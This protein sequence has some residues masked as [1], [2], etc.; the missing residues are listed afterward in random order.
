MYNAVTKHPEPESGAGQSLGSNKLPPY[1]LQLSSD[2]GPNRNRLRQFGTHAHWFIAAMTTCFLVSSYTSA[3]AENN[4][5]PVAHLAAEINLSSIGYRGFAGMARLA[6]QANLSLDFVDSTHV[7]VTFNAKKLLQR[8]P[9]CPPT[10]QDRLMHVAILEVPSGKIVKQTDWYL[11]D[12]KRYLWPLGSGRFLLRKL[13]TLYVVDSSLQEKTL[14]TSPKEFL[15]LTV[16]PNGKQIIAETADD[17]PTKKPKLDQAK[18]QQKVKIDFLDVATLAVQ[19]T[20]RSEGIVTLEGTSSGFADV[21]HNI[22]GKVWLIRFGP[23]S[24]QRENIARVRSHCIPDVF[25]SSASTLLIGRCSPSGPDYSVSAFTVTGHHLWRQHW[26]TPRYVPKIGH[27]EDGSRFAVSTL[28]RVELPTVVAAAIDGDEETDDADHGLEQGIQVFDTANGT[29]VLSLKVSPVVL[30]AQNFSLSPD[31]TRLI[32]LNDSSLRL[33]DLPAM[34]EADRARSSAVNADVPGLYMSSSELEIHVAADKDDPA[35]GAAEAVPNTEGSTTAEEKEAPAKE[36]DSVSTPA[37]PVANADSHFDK[38]AEPSLVTFKSSSRI[39]VVDVVVTD[40]KGKTVTGLRVED[41]RVS[42]DGKPQNISNFEAAD[43]EAPPASA[44]ATPRTTSEPPPRLPLNVYTNNTA[45]QAKT[46]AESRSATLILLDLLNTSVQDQAYAREQLV[47]FLHGNHAGGPFALC[48]LS[49]NLRLIQ[50]FTPEENLLLAAVN[51]KKGGVKSNPWQN[52]AGL[53]REIQFRKDLSLLDTNAQFTEQLLQQQQD[54]QMAHNADMRMRF[55]LDAF[56]QLSRYLSGIPGRKNVIWLSGSFPINIFPNPGLIEQTGVMRNYTADIKKATNLLAEAHI[57]VYPVSLKGANTQPMFS[58]S[59]NGEYRPPQVAG[60]LAPS[61]PGG[62]GNPAVVNRASSLA[63]P[64]RME[65]ETQQFRETDSSE[66]ASMEQ[67]AGDT[68]G[69]AFHSAN[70]IGD[71]IAAA[72]DQGA[73][74]YSLSYSSSNHKY[75]GGFRKIKV[76]LEQKGYHVAYRQGYYAVDPN[77]PLKETKDPARRIGIAAMQ[78]GSPESHQIIFAV[79]V[80]PIGKAKKVDAAIGGMAAAPPKKKNGPA[81]LVEMQH[82]GI[83]YAVDPAD[84]LFT[85]TSAGL[86]HGVV[87][88][89]VTA[90]ND[91]GRLVA[92]MASMAA[93]DLRPGNYKSVMAGGF[94]LHQELDVPVEAVALRLGVEDGTSNHLGTLEIPLPVPVPPEQPRAAVRSLPE[95]EPD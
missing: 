2:S 73:H 26:S 45:N 84:L 13:N 88:F 5:A 1:M 52:D 15:W 86:Y 53:E 68:G 81:G 11:H 3:G 57:A 39:V 76:A 74:Y 46:T 56:A 64:S 54:E 58:A 43:S 55:T 41:F 75:D 51:G 23:N 93:S 30:S 28:M 21:S 90:F 69:K 63:M 37:Q 59:N 27:S 80:L 29:A 67:V 35:F 19:R 44:E 66:E 24:R 16:T 36:D 77:A 60:S 8:L 38:N 4:V 22:S 72:A 89:M 18:S 94:R 31:G 85:Q 6:S 50:G 47:K 82:Y 40:Q 70:G 95:I 65:D 92:S 32:V 79:R 33:Y 25:Y 34:S 12:N 14:L 48:T 42:E 10:H 17:A 87:D 83:D 78:Q 61:G 62:A 49:S 9:D 20:I 91:D 71:A 7:L